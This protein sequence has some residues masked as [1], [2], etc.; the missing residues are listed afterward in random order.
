ME[1]LCGYA[2]C[3]ENLR[4]VHPNHLNMR[5]IIASESDERLKSTT[6]AI[7]ARKGGGKGSLKFWDELEAGDQRKA[8]SG[9]EFSP[10]ELPVLLSTSSTNLRLLL[11]T[12]RLLGDDTLLTLDDIVDVSPVGFPAESK[13]TL[14]TLVISTRSG[15]PFQITVSPGEEF[16][17]MWSVLLHF[18]RLNRK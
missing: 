17:G 13:S 9:F 8:S 6:S 4:V 5:R 7:F 15:A 2:L 16:L 11:T 3:V 14:S 10:G 1:D 18:A 12:K